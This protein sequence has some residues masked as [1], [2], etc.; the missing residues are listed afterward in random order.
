MAMSDDFAENISLPQAIEQS[1][2]ESP[3]REALLRAVEAH[4]REK[5]IAPGDYSLCVLAR[6][7]SAE[8]QDAATG[9]RR[10]GNG[11]EG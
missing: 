9:G 3:A 10:S 11:G 6:P 2:E 7:A 5:G 4:W 1:R 8:E